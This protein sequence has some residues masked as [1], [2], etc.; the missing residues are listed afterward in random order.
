MQQVEIKLLITLIVIFEST[1]YKVLF[2]TFKEIHKMNS[3][4]TESVIRESGI[5]YVF[6]PE[7]IT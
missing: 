7:I 3:F 2:E 6:I 4:P 1:I 5:S